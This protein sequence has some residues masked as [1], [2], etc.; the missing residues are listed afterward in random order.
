MTAQHKWEQ[1]IVK[2]LFKKGDQLCNSFGLDSV[3]Q[4]IALMT[5]EDVEFIIDELMAERGNSKRPRQASI[6]YAMAWVK[7][8]KASLREDNRNHLQ[9]ALAK[10]RNK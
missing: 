4:Q 7:N 8:I 1:Q 3:D 10:L 9:A 5:L 6:L 2:A